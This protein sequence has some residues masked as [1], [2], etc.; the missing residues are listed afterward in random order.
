MTVKACPHCGAVLPDEASFCPGC[1]KSVVIREKSGV[2][3]GGTFG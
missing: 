3:S 1:A 2:A